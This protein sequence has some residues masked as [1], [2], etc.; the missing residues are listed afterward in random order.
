[1][2]IIIVKQ[3]KIMMGTIS[4]KDVIRVKHMIGAKEIM[5]MIANV[6]ASVNVSVINMTAVRKVIVVHQYV[7]VADQLKRM[8]VSILI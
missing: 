4:T 6:N 5:I 3:Q 8:E 2:S 1:V 7:K